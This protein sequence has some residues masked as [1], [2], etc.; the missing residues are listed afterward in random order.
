[1][2][3]LNRKHRKPEGANKYHIDCNELEKNP[4]LIPIIIKNVI[5]NKN[6]TTILQSIITDKSITQ[7]NRNIVVKIGKINR[8]IEKEFNIGKQLENE[9]LTGFINYICLFN[10]Y[11]NTYN[12]L[13]V[14]IEKNNNNIESL[15]SAKKKEE[16]LK[17]VLIMPY[18]NEGSIK[19]FKWNK[20]KYDALKSV[21]LQ[22]I[23]SV[24]TAYQLC[25]FLH[26]DL[27]L[28]NILIKKTK[29]ET[30]NYK[31]KNEKD[32][33]KDIEINIKADGY[34]IVIMDFE[35]SMI[36]IKDKD[37]LRTYWSN[38]LNMMLRLYHDIKNEDNDIIRM[39]NL[40]NITS[41]IE[42]QE[43]S[44]ENIMNT[45]ILLDMIKD[46]K[47]IIIKQ[48]KSKLIY[49]PNVY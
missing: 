12:N 16:N 34:K 30:F 45:F 17:T 6:D 21:I 7:N 5:Q 4:S 49:D 13:K 25:G 20:E 11:D 42:K 41:F 18:I 26:N 1:M 33:N 19:N 10:C 36:N 44:N 32:K 40:S 31:F 35:N 22:T 39:D 48:I 23:M 43:K 2:N 8:T 29:K 38:L 46:A 14:D 9:K 47:F 27:H 15:C 28:D 37:G 3:S 24:F